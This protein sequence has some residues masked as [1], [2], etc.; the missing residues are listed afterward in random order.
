MF[1]F[2]IIMVL[3]Y[4]VV[5]QSQNLEH[6]LEEN[7]VTMVKVRSYTFKMVKIEK[8]VKRGENIS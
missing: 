8:G 6:S 7:L 1:T 2:E 3:F 4:G 5:I